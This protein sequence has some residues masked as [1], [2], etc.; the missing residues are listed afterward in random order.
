[1]K[2]IT[3][4]TLVRWRPL[5]DTP[6]WNPVSDL[7]SEIVSMQRDI[8]RMFDRFRGGISDDNNTSAWTPAVDIAEEPDKFIFHAELPGVDKKDVKI[9]I[10]K[11]V[12]SVRGEKKHEEEKDGKNYH[13]VERSYGSFFRSFSLPSTVLSDKIEASYADGIL[14][15]SIPKAEE[16]KPKEIEVKVK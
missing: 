15:I 16:A 11:N 1:M 2:G 12:L 9:T 13:R 4:M 3:S 7:T 8:D 6:T 14:T 10:Q 5:H